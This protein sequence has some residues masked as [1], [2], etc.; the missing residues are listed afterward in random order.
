MTTRHHHGASR[1]ARGEFPGGDWIRRNTLTA[2]IIA[3]ALALITIAVIVIAMSGGSSAAHPAKAP[4][5]APATAGTRWVD[6]SA[7]AN[8][9]AVN[10]GVIALTNAA[11]MHS[12]G[13]GTAAGTRLAAAAT[14]ALH[15]AMPPV[16]AGVYRAALAV[17]VR[18]G[19]AAAAGKLARAMPLVNDGI[20]GLIAVTASV[21][22]PKPR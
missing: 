8:L 18:A 1:V 17:L 22:A 12:L 14:T 5:K 15:G 11:T 19:H 20:A 2:G 9:N 7:N 4:A 10:A 16:D 13:A 6:G 21:N 3:G